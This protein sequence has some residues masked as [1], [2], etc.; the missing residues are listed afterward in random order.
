MVVRRVQRI[1]A[2]PLILNLRAIGQGETHAAQHAHRFIAHNGNG[3]QATGR[4]RGTW[5]RKVHTGHG[6][7]IN[8]LLQGCLAVFQR[9]GDSGTGFIQQRTHGGLVFLGHIAHALLHLGE[10]TFLAQ[11]THAGILQRFHIGYAGYARQ[12]FCLYACNLIFHKFAGNYTRVGAFV[13]HYAPC[14]VSTEHDIDLTAQKTKRPPPQK[15]RKLL[16]MRF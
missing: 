4:Q 1:E 16:T 3:M 2:V 14:S 8:L 12:G 11:N 9:G 15:K 5:H 7:G 10:G 6:S 13:K